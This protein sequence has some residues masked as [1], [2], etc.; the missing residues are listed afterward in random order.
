MK[1]PGSVTEIGN[2]SAIGRPDGSKM[3]GKA[4][5]ELGGLSS[6]DRY[7]KQIAEKVKDQS[8]AVWRKIH[9]H[10]GAFVRGKVD[11]PCRLDG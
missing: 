6:G 9:V 3:E 1:I 8:A 4:P 2:F 5:G 7:C 10:V 11:C